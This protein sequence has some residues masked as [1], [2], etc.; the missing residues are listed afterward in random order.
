[1]PGSFLGSYPA[2]DVCG[3]NLGGYEPKCGH[4]AALMPA[5]NASGRCGEA[6]RSAVNRA[7]STKKLEGESLP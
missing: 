4:C 5:G 3:Q 1:M 2:W 6:G 7:C